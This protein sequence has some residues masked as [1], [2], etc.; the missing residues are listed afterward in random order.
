[1][2]ELEQ[3]ILSKSRPVQKE[4][5]QLQKPELDRLIIEAFLGEAPA[6]PE[7]KKA[8]LQKIALASIP[9]DIKS[10]KQKSGN[11]IVIRFA[12]SAARDENTS[13]LKKELEDAG[14]KVADK[15]VPN[16][17]TRPVSDVSSDNPELKGDL[18]LIYKFDIKTR[19]GLAFEHILVYA[20]DN[21]VTKKL[22]DRLDLESSA[23]DEEVRQTLSQDPWK[24]YY[25]RAK[26]AAD[27][28][29]EK[30]GGIKDAAVVGGGGSKADLL[31]VLD[32]GDRVGISLKIALKG[33]NDFIFNKDLG[34]GTGNN[35][36]IPAPEGEPWWMVGRKRFYNLLRKNG[37]VD[38][39]VVYKPSKTDF[40]APEWMIDAKRGEDK[41]LTPLY[42]QAVGSVFSDV[43]DRLEASLKSMT[44]EELADLVN[45]AHLG[46]PATDA[47]PLYKLSSKPS[48]ATIEEVPDSSPDE[49]AIEQEGITV[50]EMIKRKGKRITID[51]PGMPNATINSVK[52]R[53]NMLSPRKGDLMIKTR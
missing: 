41:K 33:Q 24:K 7:L 51:I 42:R 20:I 6:S 36:I 37:Q 27:V 53:S 28:L 9:L 13:K 35:S 21:Q 50:P 5:K 34:D 39:T 26:L 32:N 12:T 15:R 49:V 18:R 23:T 31:I 40:E 19:I 46:K 38:E 8:V 47:P 25:D 48:G 16:L 2:K 4:V 14:F 52:F 3:L 1:M 30:F 43:L 22:K 29:E 17:S 44:I 11:Q 45:E 10:A